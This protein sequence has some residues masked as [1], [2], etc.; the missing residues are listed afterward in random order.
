MLAG[1]HKK[2]YRVQHAEIYLLDL[3]VQDKH[4]MKLPFA[5]VSKH[6]FCTSASP[7]TMRITTQTAI[8]M[9]SQRLSPPENKY[10]FY[11]NFACF[12]KTNLQFNKWVDLVCCRDSVEER[13]LDTGQKVISHLIIYRQHCYL[14][15][16]CIR[17]TQN[18]TFETDLY[19]MLVIRCRPM[20]NKDSEV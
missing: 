18:S 19:R 9:I 2:F 5:M 3:K 4:K 17:C 13:K 20:I 6:I 7:T 16:N 15:L 8:L 10:K 12:S 14:H 1:A 11:C